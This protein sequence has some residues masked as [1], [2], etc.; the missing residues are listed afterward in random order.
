MSASKKKVTAKEPEEKL[1][2]LQTE[3]AKMKELAARAQAD[4]QNM[5]ARLGREGE[6]L[7]MF[8]LASFLTSL[9][10]TLDHMERA[11]KHLPKELEGHEWAKGISATVQELERVLERVG[12]RT[13]ESL[14]KPLDPHR[15]EVLMTA[16]GEAGKV[17]EVLEEGY[18]FKGRVLRPAKV[19]VGVQETGKENGNGC[20]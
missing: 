17:I 4:L 11:R 9:L 15:H 5:K 20:C 3:F 14:G 2:A 18:E 7:R 19:K 12:L 10:P 8:A 16:P 1:H 13:F 6:E